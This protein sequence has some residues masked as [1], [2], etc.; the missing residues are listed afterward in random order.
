MQATRRK[1]VNSITSRFN[2]GV[3]ALGE[4]N[5]KRS[6]ITARLYHSGGGPMQLL[7]KQQR[8]AKSRAA[9]KSTREKRRL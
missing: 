6:S 3:R 7:Q 4:E 2:D 1:D 8:P 9:E 5:G